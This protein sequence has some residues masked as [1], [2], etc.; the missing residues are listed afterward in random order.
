MAVKIKQRKGKWW[1]FIDH[2]GRRKA[3]CVGV[4]KRAAE[5]AAAK[6]AAKLALGEFNL[7]AS[8][9]QSRPFDAYYLAWLDSYA[10]THCKASTC[11]EYDSVYRTHLLPHFGKRDIAD[12]KR[13]DVKALIAAIAAKGRTRGTI[14]RVLAPFREMLNHALEDGHVATNPASNV[15]RRTRLDAGT[16]RAAEFLTRDELAHLLSVCRT[17]EPNSYALI[18]LLARTGVRLGEAVALQWDDIDWHGG[19]ANIQRSYSKRRYSTPKSGKGR[20][21][22]VSDHL[23]DVLSTRHVAAKKQALRTGTPLAPWVFPGDP[24]NQPMDA[25]NFRRRQWARVLKEAKV[26]ALRLHALRHTYASLLIGQSES[27]AYVRDQ[28]G[29]HSIQITVDTYG[30]L[31]PGGNRAAVNRLDDASATQSPASPAASS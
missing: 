17:H 15:L 25:S 14:M 4:S 20:R 8:A 19:F 1:L 26:H 30:H 24:P 27:L 22:D 9:R 16:K 28:L 10:R 29:H 31:V 3:K 23:L 11:A 6:I 2:Q 12:I 18:L 7:D 21:V 13:E 5:A